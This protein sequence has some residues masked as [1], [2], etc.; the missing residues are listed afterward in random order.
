MVADGGGVALAAVAAAGRAQL[1]GG[2]RGRRRE[3]GGGDRRDGQPSALPR[4]ERR[5]LPRVEHPHHRGEVVGVELAG[6]VRA[7]HAELAGR[8]Q[9]VG[10]G[11]GRVDGERRP[12]VGGGEDLPVPED[13]GE[14]AL[15]Q[16]AGELAAERRGGRA[17]NG[18]D[19]HGART[20]RSARR[21]SRVAVRVLSGGCFVAPRLRRA[22]PPGFR[23][24]ARPRRTAARPPRRCCSA[25]SRRGRR[26]RAPPARAPPSATAR[27]SCRPR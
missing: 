17:G 21:A 6:D 24:L 9:R 12:L 27:S 18:R 2:A 26:R 15:R 13:D 3:A 10:D 16:G 5:R 1:G 25:G 8:A 19:G 23:D 14:R 4:V 7:A 20:S 22:R 11:L